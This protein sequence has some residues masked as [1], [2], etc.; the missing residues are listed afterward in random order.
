MSRLEGGSVTPNPQPFALRPWLETLGA[1]FTVLAEQQGIEFRLFA[2]DIRVN[3]DPKLLR[4][5]VQNFL[6]NAFR[7][8][9]GKVLLGVRREGEH[10]RLE[11]WDC[12]PGIPKDKL[13][14]I[15]EEFKRLDSHQTREEKGLG[16]GLAIADGL[17]KLLAH[18]IRVQSRLGKGSVFSV[19]I[20]LYRGQLQAVVSAPV[21]AHSTQP[22]KGIKVLCID[23]EESILTGMQSL[24]SRWGCDVRT[25]LNT[26]AC[27][28]VLKP[29]ILYHRLY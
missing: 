29:K 12:G 5:I 1:E 8:A 17:C 18:P 7:Y 16:L 19:T 10:I 6:T 13:N 24:L 28:T 11:V 2:P 20:P 4:R 27:E 25:A 14:F 15:F 23:N 21:K 9:K 26:S 3:S 22:L